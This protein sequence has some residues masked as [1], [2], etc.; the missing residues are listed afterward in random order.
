MPPALPPAPEQQARARIDALLQAAGWVLQDAA[1]FNR[2]AAPGVAVREFQLPGGPCD[3]LLFVAGKAC[4]VIEAK[5][6]G[7]TLSGVAEQA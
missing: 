2:N 5:K 4:G 1:D 6:A 7:I 3:Y